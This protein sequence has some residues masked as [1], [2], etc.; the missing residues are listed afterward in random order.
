MSQQPLI[1]P[2]T[3]LTE[4]IGPVRWSPPPAPPEPDTTT[5]P[6]S[7][8]AR[9]MCRGMPVEAPTLPTPGTAE[10]EAARMAFS[11]PRLRTQRV[12]TPSPPVVP[13]LPVGAFFMTPSGSV[14][15]PAWL[16]VAGPEAA[17]EKGE[18]DAT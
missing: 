11:T 12:E 17:P 4:A 3:V 7:P 10:Q 8:L 14:A 5:P 6:E 18:T 13:L 15:T 9:A 1:P 16:T 2:C